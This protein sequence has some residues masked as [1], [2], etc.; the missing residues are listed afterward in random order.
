MA[1]RAEGTTKDANRARIAM[2]DQQFDE[3][4]GG[5]AMF[6]VWFVLHG[7]VISKQ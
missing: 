2:D 4:E 6:V 3:S 1:F 7:L 5:A